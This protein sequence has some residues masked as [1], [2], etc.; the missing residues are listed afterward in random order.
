MSRKRSYPILGSSLF[1]AGS[2]IGAGMLAL[3]VL[4]GL[5][6][7][8]PSLVNLCIAWAFMT[9]SSCLVLEMNS[10]F[11][12]RVNLLSMLEKGLG[13]WGK[14]LCFFSYLFLFYTLCVAYIAASG[15]LIARL[16]PGEWFSIE[17]SSCLFVLLLTPCIY[18]GTKVT[19]YL[20]RLL[21]FGLFF[22]F[23][24]MIL[25]GLPNIDLRYFLHVDGR[26]LLLS[27]PVLVLSFGFQN[28]IPSLSAYLE[29]D[30]KSV[31]TAIL[32]GSLSVLIIYL[33]WQILFIGTVPFAGK[34]GILALYESREDATAPLY[35]L[36]I[37][38]LSQGFAFFAII[39]SFLAQSL[40]LVHFLADALHVPLTRKNRA[41][42]SAVTLG[43]SLLIAIS[44]PHIFYEALQFAGGFCAMLLFGVL[45]V[46]AVF[47]GRYV[48]KI[49]ASYRAIGGKATLGCAGIFA[50]F[51]L[52]QEMEKMLGAFL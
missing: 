38:S 35:S 25:W 16:S 29:R 48:A 22:T 13:P 30:W 39:T 28:T 3:P 41:W 21:V 33:L 12:N 26:F 47:R 23:F 51:L 9:Y 1:I 27:L 10:W 7:F 31:Q 6:G 52:I 14:R 37:G 11:P 8:F 49:P 19:D 4:T 20:N 34:S 44:Y 43:P 42:L 32:G 36:G 40:T 50:L 17:I 15:R 5:A 46:G 18:L 2:C 45:P 24:S